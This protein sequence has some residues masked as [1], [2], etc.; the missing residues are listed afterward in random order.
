MM[1]PVSNDGHKPEILFIVQNVGLVYFT[2]SEQLNLTAG[3]LSCFIREFFFLIL[4]LCVSVV[5][6]PYLCFGM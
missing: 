4:K 5:L 1:I 2:I 6:F 3:V